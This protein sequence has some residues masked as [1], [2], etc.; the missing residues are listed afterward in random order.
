[1]NA[2]DAARDFLAKATDLTGEALR[3]ALTVLP[4]EVKTAY[5]AMRKASYFKPENANP[6]SRKEHLSPSG[7]Y[8]LVKTFIRI[9]DPL[10]EERG[11]F[12][13]EVRAP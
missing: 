4:D 10:S 3:A 9:E 8:K 1:M 11:R 6:E 5:Y 12:D 13:D 2:I 7:R